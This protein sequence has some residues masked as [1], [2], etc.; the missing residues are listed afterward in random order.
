MNDAPPPL[1]P[2]LPPPP[3][4]PPLRPPPP[5]PPESPF[6][7]M[8]FSSLFLFLLFPSIF[9]PSFAKRFSGHESKIALHARACVPLPPSSS[10]SS[11]S[12][13]SLERERGGVGKAE[14]QSPRASVATSGRKSVL[15]RRGTQFCCMKNSSFR[16]YTQRACLTCQV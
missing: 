4:P 13:H 6:L 12:S 11:S 16:W 3:P 15:I 10:S 14:D 1:P 2:S 7:P 9:F 5:P 8:P